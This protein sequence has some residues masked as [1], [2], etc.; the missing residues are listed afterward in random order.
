MF[1]SLV[2]QNRTGRT[3]PGDV[4]LRVVV[5]LFVKLLFYEVLKCFNQNTLTIANNFCT[6]CI[7][8]KK[9]CFS[10]PAV[11]VPTGVRCCVPSVP[12]AKA[13]PDVVGYIYYYLWDNIYNNGTLQT[14]QVRY[15]FRT[16]S[17][18]PVPFLP[19]GTSLPVPLRLHPD[20]ACWE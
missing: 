12:D 15:S 5:Q 16:R 20:M 11:P 18:I 8:N 6:L 9:L 10:G 1:Y 14:K 4:I 2:M 19:E 3:S 13:T 7:L 17:V